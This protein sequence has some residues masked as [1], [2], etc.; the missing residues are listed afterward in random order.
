MP[1]AGA[2]RKTIQLH[3]RSCDLHQRLAQDPRRAQANQFAERAFPLLNMQR[4]YA[5][6]R[7]DPDLDVNAQSN[8]WLRESV[9][10]LRKNYRLVQ[11]ALRQLVPQISRK[12]ESLLRSSVH[13]NG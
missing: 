9:P 6:K 10:L 4:V 2:V 5:V 7:C 12:E 13:D 11:P 8:A 1:R 3:H